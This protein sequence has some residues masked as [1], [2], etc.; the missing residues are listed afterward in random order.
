MQRGGGP[1]K[2]AVHSKAI[3]LGERVSGERTAGRN[4]L[5]HAA[6][7]ELLRS[8]WGKCGWG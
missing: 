3:E 5:R 1:V 7:C 2:F 8:T 6:E 4:V